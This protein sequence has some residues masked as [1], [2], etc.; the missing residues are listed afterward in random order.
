MPTPLHPRRSAEVNAPETWDSWGLI[1]RNG[2]L[3]WPD[4]PP[5][6]FIAMEVRLL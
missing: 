1:H 2:S 3:K 6:A 5:V 4:F